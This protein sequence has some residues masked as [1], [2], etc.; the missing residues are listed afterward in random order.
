[1]NAADSEASEYP[2]ERA[3]ARRVALDVGVAPLRGRRTQPLLLSRYFL[4]I[5][6]SR[7]SLSPNLS[8]HSQIARCAH[9][10]SHCIVVADSTRCGVGLYRQFDHSHGSALS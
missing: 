9:G 3:G 10:F 1:M 2:S 8:A 7:V 6:A 5:L 4:T